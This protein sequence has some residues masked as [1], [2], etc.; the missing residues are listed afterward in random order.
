LKVSKSCLRRNAWCIAFCECVW[1]FACTWSKRFGYP[2]ASSRM[3]CCGIPTHKLC[4]SLMKFLVMCVSAINC[5]N[6]NVLRYIILFL[7]GVIKVT[8]SVGYFSRSYYVRWF[9]GNIY[10]PNILHRTFP[11]F[12]TRLLLACC[13][14][15]KSR[16]L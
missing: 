4:I 13:G 6:I 2:V 9:K 15:D 3:S 10:T 8:Y 7:C 14:S 1:C 5:G 16:I 12:E 11:S